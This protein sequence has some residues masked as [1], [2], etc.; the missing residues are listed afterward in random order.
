MKYLITPILLLLTA[1]ASTSGSQMPHTAA[2]VWNAR[3]SR[4]EEAFTM[5]PSPECDAL[6][7]SRRTWGAVAV[8]AAIGAG[9]GGGI[10]ALFTDATPRAVVG[11]T[12][13]S[14]A[15]F[16]AVA[17]YLTNDYA[18][19]YRDHGCMNLSYAPSGQ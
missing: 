12:T 9:T 8:G 3:V 4:V 17:A 14:T 10:T 5:V 6:D 18:T 2:I 15:I 7:S 13:L 19:S 11:I 1:C 16:S